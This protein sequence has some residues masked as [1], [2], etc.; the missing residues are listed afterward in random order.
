MNNLK[1]FITNLV[2]KHDAKNVAKRHDLFVINNCR[3]PA[4]IINKINCKEWNSELINKEKLLELVKHNY[5]FQDEK[6][7]I[8]WNFINQL[9]LYPI[10]LMKSETNGI[11]KWVNTKNELMFIGKI[12][13]GHVPGKIDI[14]RSILIADFGNGFDTVI[15][16]DFSESSQNPSVIFSYWSSH[17]EVNVTWIKIAEN[18]CNFEELVWL[19]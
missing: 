14:N 11:K 6:C 1:N 3:I 9:M 2:K 18:Y 16:L 7:E 13:T 8:D 17:P 15:A 12:D 19:K 5:P 4:T 10:E